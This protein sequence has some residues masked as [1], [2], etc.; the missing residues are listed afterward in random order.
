VGE[1]GLARQGLLVLALLAFAGFQLPAA[2]GA[3]SPARLHRD[4]EALRAES[5]SLN[6]AARAAWLSVISLDTRLEQTQAAFLRLGARAEAI[7]RAR[8]EAE[9][10]LRLAR[11]NLKISEQRLASRLRALY[12]Q[13]DTDPLAVVL[14]ASSMGEAL[15]GLDSVNRVAEQDRQLVEALRAARARLVRLTRRLAAREAEARRAQAAAAAIAVSLAAARAERAGMLAR[16]RARARAGSARAASLDAQARA[17][18]EEQP[19]TPGAPAAPAAETRELTVTATGYALRGRT[20][21]GVSV[22]WGIVAVD[23][24]VI[25]LGTRISIP[26]YGEGVAADTGGAVRGARIDL[27]F[28]TQAE[29]LA[30]GSRTIT[31][32]LL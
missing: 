28:P 1:R 17:L 16:L 23:P 4:A 5:S 12:V 15:E 18:A 7:A 31:I 20:A 25:A 10:R 13:G 6:R 22:G 21:T 14:G 3:G 24:S 26:G 11:R 19:S 8:A 2:G 9:L 27:W 30:W 29:A 32:T